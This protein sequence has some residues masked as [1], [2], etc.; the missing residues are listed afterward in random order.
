MFI[1]MI[2]SKALLWNGV[3]FMNRPCL[4]LWRIRK[5][6]FIVMRFSSSWV[7]E[8]EKH[9]ILY[10]DRETIRSAEM[11]K[12]NNPKNLT[13]SDHCYSSAL[14]CSRGTSRGVFCY[15]SSCIFFK[16]ECNVINERNLTTPIQE[17]F[18]FT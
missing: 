5:H 2:L 11:Q 10:S 4:Y 13:S 12:C 14:L 18:N 6:L 1:S 7:L 15:S 8:M 16:K 17:Y 9:F 3:I